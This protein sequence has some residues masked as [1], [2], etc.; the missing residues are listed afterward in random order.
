MF[1]DRQERKSLYISH[2]CHT[3]TCLVHTA[4]TIRIRYF[5]DSLLE[6]GRPVMLVGNAG[7]GKSVLIENNLGSMDFNKYMIKNVPF[8][9][10]TTSAMLQGRD[11]LQQTTVLYEENMVIFACETGC[12][13][14]SG[15]L[16]E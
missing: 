15:R 8:N 3:Q 2:L 5:M 14:S 12:V 9:Y 6:H 10:Y 16:L 13:E 1:F 7:M 4:E 11:F